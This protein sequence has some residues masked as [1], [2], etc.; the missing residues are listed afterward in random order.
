VPSDAEWIIIET[1]LGGSSVTGGKM[2]EI[3]T[4][5]WNSP[6][7]GATNESGF[8]ALPGGYRC[9]Y[10]GSFYNLGTNGY[11]WSATE[12]SGSKA[13]LRKLTYNNDDAY[14]EWNG[15]YKSYGFSVRCIK[16]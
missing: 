15:N 4:T 11:W 5:H 14:R 8:L 9:Y 7:T 16:D 3:G 12:Y 13:W 2:K 1:Y 6:N 10:Y